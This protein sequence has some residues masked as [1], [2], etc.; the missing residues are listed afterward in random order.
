MSISKFFELVEIKTKLASMIPFSLGSAYAIY[1]YKSFDLKN[2]IIMFISLIC[3]DMATTA[4]NNYIDHTK[5]KDNGGNNSLITK[6]GVNKSKVLFI[7]F[8]LL[9]IATTAGVMLTLNTNIIVLLIG[10]ISFIVG[11]F[12]TFGPIPISRMPLGEVFSGFFMGF[13]IIFLSVYIHIF[14]T[15]IISFTYQNNILSVGINLIEIVWIFLFSIPAMGGI[16]NIMLANNICDV[17]EDIQ[18]NR[19]TLPYYIGRP[20]ALKLFKLLY[21]IGYVNIVL[22]VVLKVI[23]LASLFMLITLIKVNKNIKLFEAKPIKNE[24]F[25]VSVKNFL[26]IN[27]SQAIIMIIIVMISK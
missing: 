4:I 14:D 10:I 16:A 9:V 7:I 21:Y 20:M 13:I 25:V 23:P 27:G 26:L 19:F 22:L 15:N 18:N 2:F 3:F 1:R 24:N 5:A 12:Y 8:T 17:E 6:Y 11:I